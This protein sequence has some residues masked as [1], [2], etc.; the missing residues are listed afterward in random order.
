MADLWRRREGALSYQVLQEFY[1]TVTR[2]L[3]MARELAR[4]DIRALLAW[5]PMAT[6]NRILEAAWSIEERYGLSW[7]D[8]LIVGAAQVAGCPRLLTED[9]QPGQDYAGVIVVSPFL[10]APGGEQS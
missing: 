5:E 9:L 8:S 10:T 7:W 6:D 3:G 1:T 4:S 2:K